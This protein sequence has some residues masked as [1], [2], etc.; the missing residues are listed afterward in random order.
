MW[1][2]MKLH[3]CSLV[4]LTL[5]KRGDLLFGEKFF[6][7]ENF[8]TK[9]LFFSKRVFVITSIFVVYCFDGV[10]QMC[11]Q[12]SQNLLGDS[13]HP[14]FTSLNM[15]LKQGAIGNTLGEQIGNL[16][17]TSWELKRN[18][19]GT[20]EKRKKSFPHP[21]CRPHTKFKRKK[22]QGTLSAWA[23]PFAA[24]NL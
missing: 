18:M 1:D 21:P 24:L 20:K 5:V 4:P 6:V 16:M 23:F 9:F 12:L 10:I 3:Y 7:F 14:S 2:Q 19:L 11:H 13:F 22:N 15:G 17:G 8:V